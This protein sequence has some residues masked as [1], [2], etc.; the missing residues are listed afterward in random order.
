MKKI[1]W[2]LILTSLTG[3]QAMSLE[4]ADH[5]ASDATD[6]VIQ[7]ITGNYTNPFDQEKFISFELLSRTVVYLE[8]YTPRGEKVCG[9]VSEEFDT[10]EHTLIWDGKNSRNEPVQSGVYILKFKAGDFEK[11]WTLAFLH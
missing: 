5:T 2:I 1:V 3:V 4:S 11:S 6:S 8:V 10:G 7:N 9:I